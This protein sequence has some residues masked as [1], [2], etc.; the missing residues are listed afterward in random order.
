MFATGIHLSLSIVVFI[1]LAYLIYFVWYPQPYYSVAG[2][3]QGMRLVAAV[4]L[5]LGPLITFLIFNP[6]KSRRE[7]TFDLVIILVI[8][9]AALSYG[10]FATYSQRPVAVVLIENTL[11]SATRGDYGDTLGSVSELSEFSDE[12]PP[13][14]LS[15]L[16]GFGGLAQSLVV[17][18]ETG[19]HAHAQIQW[20]LP[21]AEL[22]SALEARQQSIIEVFEIDAAGDRLAAWLRDNNL[23]R[24]DVMLSRF[25]GR[26]GPAWMVFDRDARY[27][28][29]FW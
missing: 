17:K 7:I 19:I 5:V 26:Y 15:S 11:V 2:G 4:D 10:V 9:F 28:G 1:V 14:I 20:Y 3:W 24:D 22:K 6:S 29:Y 12:Q 21:A 13:M 18:K 8:Q 23:S 25:E 16:S 27:L